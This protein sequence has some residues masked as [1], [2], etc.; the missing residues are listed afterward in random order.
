MNSDNLIIAI[1]LK[2]LENKDIIASHL[3]LFIGLDT[4]S[5]R[6]LNFSPM[7]WCESILELYLIG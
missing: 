1:I 2:V 5:N 4:F 6:R 3:V 7:V